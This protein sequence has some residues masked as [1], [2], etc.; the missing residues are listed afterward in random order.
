MSIITGPI[1]KPSTPLHITS[2]PNLKVFRNVGSIRKY[3]AGRDLFSEVSEHVLVIT[4]GNEP[5]T[6]R[7]ID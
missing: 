4:V 7:L 1:A 6:F 2:A 3:S 5:G